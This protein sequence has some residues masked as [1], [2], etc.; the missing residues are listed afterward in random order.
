MLIGGGAIVA[1]GIAVGLSFA[2]SNASTLTD[3]AGEPIAVSAIVVP[4][5]AVTATPTPVK[6]PKPTPVATP[7]V[8][9]AP[10]PRDVAPEPDPEPVAPAE[11]APADPVVPAPQPSPTQEQIEETIRE[12]A[13][14][15]DWDGLRA[16]VAGQ[17]WSPE[18]IQAII[19]DLR[20]KYPD[21]GRAET[22]AL[23]D[24]TSDRDL[25]GSGVGS[26]RD[27]SHRAP[28]SG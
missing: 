6:S 5:P 11:P 26:K 8:V 18:E 4:A 28:V 14:K 7:E 12:F 17:G 25:P 1:A 23:A 15:G 19:D 21:F 13:A 2:V 22:S 27:Q 10:Q 24:P 9:P 20:Q 3:I 16:W